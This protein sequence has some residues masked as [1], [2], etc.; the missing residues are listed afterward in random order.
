M[1]RALFSA[2]AG[3]QAQQ[4]NLDN[5]ANNLANVNTAGFKRSRADFQDLFYQTFRPAGAATASGAEIPVG[6]QVG[7]GSKLVA[8]QRIYVQGD[9]Q[10]TENPLDLMIEGD[11]FFQVL[12]S[13]GTTGYTRGGSFKRDA[14]GRVVTSDGLALQPE[15]AIPAQAGVVHV[16]SDGT[17]SAT[18]PGQTASQQIGK[19]ELSRF[20]NP[21]G[22]NSVG[23]SL[24]LATSASGDPISGEPG[25]EGRGTIGQ[26][27]LELSN[28]KVV[29][30][31]VNLIMA[32]RAYETG[33]KA[34]QA[35]D[36]MLQVSNNIRR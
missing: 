35:A 20:T 29:E 27:F 15:V 30:E 32:Q 25:K 23:R 10:E 33:S 28:V 14:N 7:H 19:I 26:G 21:A 6:V 9:P 16:G 1:I 17:V 11:G 8:I 31:M 34:V 4:L 18:M 3:M 24:F 36:E 22:L 5:I 13:D 2:A 12:R